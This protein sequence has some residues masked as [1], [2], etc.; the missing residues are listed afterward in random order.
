[1]KKIQITIFLLASSSIAWSQNSF[2]LLS[3][4]QYTGG[5]GDLTNIVSPQL[6]LEGVTT[7]PRIVHLSASSTVSSVY[8][9]QTGKNVYWGESLDDGQYLFRGRDFIVEQGNVGIGTNSPSAK[10]DIL[11]SGGSTGNSSALRLRA[12]NS[13]A[14]AG[15][16]Q[17]LLSYQAGKLY[18]HAIKT[19]HHS[20]EEIGNSIDF[21]VWQPSDQSS[22]VGSKHVMSLN[23]GNVGIGTTSPN[24]PLSVRKDNG[25]SNTIHPLASFSRLSSGAGNAGLNV[26]YEANGSATTRT[27]LYFPGGLGA[28]FQVYNQGALDVLHLDPSG[29]VGIGTTNPQSKLAVDGHIRATE[30]K[31]LADITV[32][33]YVFESDYDL[34]T[35]KETKAYIVEN[36]HLPEIPSA[37]EIG[38]NGID[39]G[40]MNMRLL[41]KIE[42]LT[43]HLIEQNE[44]LEKAEKKISKL[45]NEN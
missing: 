35:L 45:E 15:N 18:S 33:D 7:Y 39:L 37:A 8:N 30:V 29:N 32:P 14:Y 1:M 23:G 38:E 27:L 36:K 42:E 5:T 24:Y 40:D 9:F 4:G 16:N 19:R 41:K 12:G 6:K 34:R 13:S 17:V 3:S 26:S 11:E 22:E 21:Y 25:V 10:L 20:Y 43:L 2:P 44:R 28:S 31:V